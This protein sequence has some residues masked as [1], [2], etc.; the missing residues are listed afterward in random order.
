MRDPPESTAVKAPLSAANFPDSSAVYFARETAR[1]SSE[2]KMSSFFL[3]PASEA[4]GAAPSVAMAAARTMGKEGEEEK[5]RGLDLILLRQISG[6]RD[7]GGDRRPVRR[8]TRAAAATVAA[9][10]EVDMAW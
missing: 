4:A 8:G 9:E 10:T 1:S 2:S 3:D 5:I 6:T 7:A